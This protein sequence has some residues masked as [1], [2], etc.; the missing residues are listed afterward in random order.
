MESLLCFPNARLVHRSEIGKYIE[1]I[2][3][4]IY[5]PVLANFIGS[6]LAYVKPSE[7]SFFFFLCAWK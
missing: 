4:M 6:Y 3:L 2:F 1:W 7:L 5:F